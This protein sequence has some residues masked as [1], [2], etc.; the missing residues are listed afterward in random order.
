[1]QAASSRATAGD[2]LESSYFKEK[3]LRECPGFL[4]LALRGAKTA[5]SPFR[6]GWVVENWP[7]ALTDGTP[8]LG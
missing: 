4:R 1:M 3:P 6:Q 8:F 2:C 7:G 5:G